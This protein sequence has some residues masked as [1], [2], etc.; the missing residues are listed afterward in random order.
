M[1]A[2]APVAAAPAPTAAPAPAAEAA[3]ID[4]SAVPE[5]TVTLFYPG[6]TSFEWIQTEHGGARAF[7]KGEACSN[8]HEGEQAD[9][10]AKM[11]SGQKAEPTPIPGKPASIPLT[12]QAA[13]DGETLTMRF[14]WPASPHTPAPFADGGKMDPENPV[15]LALLIDQGTVQDADRS[16][17][18]STCHHDARSMPDAPAGGGVTKYLPQTRSAISLRDAPRGGADK[19]K[20]ADELKALMDQGV[21]LDLLRWKSGSNAVEDGYVSAERVMSGGQGAS[22]HGVLKD[23]V[24]TVTLTRALKSASP[25]DVSIEPGKTYTIGFAIHDDHTS[26]RF[27]HVSVDY[28]LALDNAEAGINAVKA[29]AVRKAAAPAAEASTEVAAV[30][31]PQEFDAYNAKDVMRTCAPCHGEFGQGGGKGTYPRLAG[32]NADYL[33]DQLRKFK[34]RERENIPM[35][36]FSNDR[37]MPDTDIRDITRYLATIKLK[38]K[39]DDGDAPADGLDR[40]LA[41]KKILHIERWDGDA[42]KGRALYAELCASCHGKAGEGRVKKPPLAGQYSEY[43]L[44]QISDFRKGRRQHD[45]VE[46]LFV[47]RHERDFDDILAFLSSLSP[48]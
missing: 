32:M 42:D 23:G 31:P 18:W 39:L 16:G 3:G 28:K 22:G 27:H 37:E 4:W 24:W 6:Q 12:V 43:L 14:R 34:S 38:T 25:G 48:S 5:K 17:C 30:E 29:A 46:P 10:G 7:K 41:A 8:C 9:M 11:A 15:K 45:D 35:I 1:P 2:P 47:Q 44:Q 40:L 20:S 36:P 33:A 13:H 19:P 26:A 21:F